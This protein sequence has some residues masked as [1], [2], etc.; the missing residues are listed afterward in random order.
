[1]KHIYYDYRVFL[2][3][4]KEAQV[5]LVMMLPSKSIADVVEAVKV[6]KLLKQS[7]I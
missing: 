3:G 5:L 1:M 6:F 4:V 7:G 2:K